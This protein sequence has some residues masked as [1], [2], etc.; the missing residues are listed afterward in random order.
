MLAQCPKAQV[1]VVAN[2]QHWVH[3]EKPETVVRAIQKFIDKE[4]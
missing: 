3:A 1:F 4:E 2:A